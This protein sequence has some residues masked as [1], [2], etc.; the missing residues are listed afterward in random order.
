MT[1]PAAPRG[2]LRDAELRRGLVLSIDAAKR[3]RLLR[4]GLANPG[5]VR[6]GELSPLV[7]GSEQAYGRGC[8]CAACRAAGTEGRARR[9]HST[10]QCGRGCRFC[11]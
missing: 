1:A 11:V 7:H 10:G 9:R 3:Q 6:L 5:K 2:L 8:K 4:A